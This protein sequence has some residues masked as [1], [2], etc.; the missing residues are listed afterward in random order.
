M[1]VAMAADL[2]KEF[3]AFLN[4]ND[5][6]DS[7][8]IECDIYD[9]ARK[10]A[11]RFSD[12]DWAALKNTYRSRSDEWKELLGATLDPEQ[13][14]VAQDILIDFAYSENSALSHDAMGQIYFRCGI[15]SGRHEVLVT[16]LDGRERLEC[17]DDGVFFDQGALNP[18]FRERL[19]GLES[20]KNT[21]P[22]AAYGHQ[23]EH[24]VLKAI[25]GLSEGYEAFCQGGET[26]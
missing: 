4:Q 8:W 25:L 10:I 15:N 11:D 20:F 1:V 19:R 13:G 26:M 2:F 9:Q 14:T 7:A 17:R 22:P 16:D 6:D 3:D 5:P 21:L 23:E 12:Q 24:E 18:A